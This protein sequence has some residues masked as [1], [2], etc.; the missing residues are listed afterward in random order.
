MTGRDKHQ[1]TWYTLLKDARSNRRH[2]WPRREALRGEGTVRCGVVAVCLALVFVGCSSGP[3]AD[4][5]Q[6]SA[7]E[8]ATDESEQVRAEP[9]ADVVQPSATESA[10]DESEQ[11]RAEPQADGLGA[12]GHNGSQRDGEGWPRPPLAGMY[13]RHPEMGFPAEGWEGIVSI[14]PPC[15]YFIF[16]SYDSSTNSYD[17]LTG[18]RRVRIALSLPYPQVRFDESTQTMWSRDIPVSHGDRVLTGGGD[19]S[20]TVGGKEPHELH[21]FWDAC[22]AQGI[23]VVSG[24][25]S[26]EW[27]CGQEPPDWPSA[28]QGWQR[29]CVEDMRPWNQRDLLEQQGFALA[30]DSPAAGLGTGGPPPVADLPPPPLHG[31]HLYH[32]DMELDLA[33]L[34]G[35]LSIE[36]AGR[37]FYSE[38]E[39]AYLYVTASSVSQAV[40]WGETWKHTGPDGQPLAVLLDLPYPQVRFDEDN[41]TLWNGDIGPMATGDRVIVDPSSLPDFNDTGYGSPKQPHETLINVACDKAN[42][43]ATVLD[44]QTV[45]RYCTHDTPARHQSQCEQAMS[46]RHQTEYQLMLPE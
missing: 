42:A 30:G 19:G 35:I 28:Q 2:P 10:T 8:S 13:A 21:L 11:V 23:G 7:T 3:Q 34:V 22:S 43:R 14:E 4:V 12:G 1:G 18:D 20:Y 37:N 41:W 27:Y 24:L 32:P 46:L 17:W 9:Q 15:V 5:V 38:R 6:P 33:K 26:V 40:L 25:E 44:I 29:I 39:C 45:E 16:D 36:P 31:M